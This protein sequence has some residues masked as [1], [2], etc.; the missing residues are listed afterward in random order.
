MAPSRRQK[1]GDR[2]DSVVLARDL[3]APPFAPRRTACEPYE[4]DHDSSQEMQMLG[5]GMNYHRRQGGS[6]ERL[7]W[8]APQV[9]HSD[10]ASSR[11]KVDE[12]GMI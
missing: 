1:G 12:T 5:S 10:T 8:G 7:T 11:A 4:Y 6:A 3:A 9:S 2:K